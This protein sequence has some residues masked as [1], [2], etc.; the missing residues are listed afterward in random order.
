MPVPPIPT[1]AKVAY[2]VMFVLVF[3][4][5][6]LLRLAYRQGLANFVLARDMVALPGALAVNLAALAWVCW[7][8]WRL[9][10]THSDARGLLL[11]LVAFD[12][13]LF[14]IVMFLEKLAW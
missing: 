5:L 11:L 2:A 1:Q 14:P 8:I 10:R 6:A 12:V 9:D 13:A 3:P 7:V 4:K